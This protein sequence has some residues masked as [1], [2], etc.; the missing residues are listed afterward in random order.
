MKKESW[1]TTIN[2]GKR[3][4]RRLRIEAAI[5][6]VPMVEILH[7]ALDEWFMNHSKDNENKKEKE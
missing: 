3:W 7:E 6:D 1:Y 2:I 5:R 4:H